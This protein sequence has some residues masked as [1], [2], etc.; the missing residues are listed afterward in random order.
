MLDSIP[1]PP[2]FAAEYSLNG[3]AKSNIQ[4]LANPS[5]SIQVNPETFVSKLAVTDSKK[6]HWTVQKKGDV[7]FLLS[8]GT[9]RGD[10]MVAFQNLFGNS[11]CLEPLAELPCKAKS[12]MVRNGLRLCFWV[13][14]LAASFKIGSYFCAR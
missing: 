8:Y 14:I 11:V 7:G 4:N 6:H 1:S 9:R 5:S 10:V 13:L 3:S 2:A 12:A